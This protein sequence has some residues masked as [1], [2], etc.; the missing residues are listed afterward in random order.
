MWEAAR[1]ERRVGPTVVRRAAENDVLPTVCL[2]QS[3]PWRTLFIVLIS[4][5]TT[6]AQRWI[7]MV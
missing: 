5:G 4:V 6:I 7:L 2:V 1:G 3:W